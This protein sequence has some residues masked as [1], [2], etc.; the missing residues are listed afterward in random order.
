MR[1]VILSGVRLKKAERAFFDHKLGNSYAAAIA[2]SQ[3]RHLLRILKE[4]CEHCIGDFHD[5][6]RVI[7]MTFKRN[8]D[9]CWNELKLKEIL[10]KWKM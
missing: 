1:N 8:C 5:N 2:K 9:L 10:S 7:T 3:A 6:D 4:P